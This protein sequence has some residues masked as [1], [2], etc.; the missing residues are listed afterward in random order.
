MLYTPQK[1]SYV[2]KVKKE[3]RL[4]RRDSQD[5]VDAKSYIILTIG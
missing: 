3:S 2:K 4:Y 5:Q 1:P